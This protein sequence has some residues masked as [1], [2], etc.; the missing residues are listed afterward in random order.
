MVRADPEAAALYSRIA[1]EH[2]QAELLTGLDDDWA[3]ARKTNKDRIAAR[4]KAWYYANRERVRA[5]Q[6]EY[7]LA[8][9]EKIRAKHR[10]YYQENWDQVRDQQQEYRD[11][12]RG[13]INARRRARRRARR[14]ESPRAKHRKQPPTTIDNQGR[15][16]VD[17]KDDPATDALPL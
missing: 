16:N 4:K 9:R 10:T 17:R 7:Y 8:N 15:R 2:L 3:A 6:R 13:D 1:A 14:G 5:K 11:I 12:N